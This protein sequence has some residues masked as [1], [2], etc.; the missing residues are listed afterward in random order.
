MASYESM[1]GTNLQI[2]VNHHILVLDITMADSKA[3]QVVH[4]IDYLAE[5]VSGLVF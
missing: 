5:D 1:L 3:I 4:G 2:L